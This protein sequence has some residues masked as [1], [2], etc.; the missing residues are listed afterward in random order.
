MS[1]KAADRLTRLLALVTY[2][3]EHPGVAVSEVA[4]HFGVTP[5]QVLADVNL[6]WVSGTPGGLHGDM[7][8]FAPDHYDEHILTLTE[9]LGMERP[10]RLGRQEA[11]AL[12]VALRSLE[13]IANAGALDAELVATTAARLQQAA[14]EAGAAA[15][16]MQLRI[17]GAAQTQ[18]TLATV[19]RAI[20]ER[21][22]LWLRY[23]SASDEVSEREV[24]PIEAVWDGAQWYVHAWCHRVAD[25]RFF[26]LDRVLDI[27]VLTAPA[28]R[29][30]AAARGSAEPDL[31]T[32]TIEAELEIEERARWV[33]EQFPVE[34]VS[35]LAGG[36][37]LLRLRVADI[38][39]LS[40][41]VFSLGDQVRALRPAE[42]REQLVA[43]AEDALA[44]YDSI[45]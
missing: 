28:E 21:R 41:L 16:A 24:D 36:R 13:G 7:I 4:E 45:A 38:A 37:L 3:D 43:A 25:D 18:E 29:H 10:L 27:R 44:A 32:V 12:L 5:D 9:S 1:E 30:D 20:T 31:T 19:R 8:D 6:L 40:N 35:E 33:A 23:V 17:S 14:G 42:L 2:L 15:D 39:W 26:R 11:L 34:E 22:R